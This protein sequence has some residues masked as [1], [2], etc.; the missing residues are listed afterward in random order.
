MR[1]IVL[2]ITW[3]IAIH[4][5][6]AESHAASFDCGK[7][8]TVV[9]KMICADEELGRF[10]G[11]LAKAYSEALAA[12]DDAA[13]P[14]LRS[15]QRRWIVEAASKCEIRD[16]RDQDDAL[17]RYCLGNVWFGRAKELV[18]TALPKQKCEQFI[19]DHVTWSGRSDG[20]DK[21]TFEG[22]DEPEWQRIPN[23]GRTAVDAA[24]A[25]FDF[26]NDGS[27]QPVFW[28]T[29]RTST[30]Y[31]STFLVAAPEDEGMIRSELGQLGGAIHWETI[32][33]DLRD[34]LNKEQ[35][36]LVYDADD[37]VI[38]NASAQ[39]VLING[40]TYNV[41]RANYNMFVLKRPLARH[42][43]EMCSVKFPA[44]Q[45]HFFVSRHEQTRFACPSELKDLF[46]VSGSRCNNTA[47][48]G[49]AEWGGKRA[50]RH[51]CHTSGRIYQN[52]QLHVGEVDGE[53]PA[54]SKWRPLEKLGGFESVVLHLTDA[55]PYIEATNWTEAEYNGE[56]EAYEKQYFR[57]A[58][59]DL[60]SVCT[61]GQKIVPPPGVRVQ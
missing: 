25:K 32:L 9:E 12:L 49:L 4:L 17:K 51:S 8:R 44:S 27:Q 57:I 41:V 16:A 39:L 26:Q 14:Q 22:S 33:S 43:E 59:G 24:W 29:V 7:A 36:S 53:V 46:I 45:V 42:M 40:S 13:K 48:L 38:G 54:E 60:I 1:L 5:Q 56:P 28:V 19:R 18:R 30:M 21:F 2:A 47:V 52:T 10:D 34:Q 35:T 61:V 50:I 20:T 15:A 37:G 3:V 55:G 31:A 11:A 23:L 6:P 58:Q